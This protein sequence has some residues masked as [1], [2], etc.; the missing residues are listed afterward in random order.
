MAK[1]L[2]LLKTAIIS[3]AIL[4]PVAGVYASTVQV[5]VNIAAVAEITRVEEKTT[6]L[7]GKEYAVTIKTNSING[8]DLYASSDGESWENV[9][10]FSGRPE[11]EDLT[12]TIKT[13]GESDLKFKVIPRQ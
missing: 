11:G 6:D 4:A 13:T 8:Y 9:R 5:T 7:G 1:K 10:E 2:N 12:S 3:G